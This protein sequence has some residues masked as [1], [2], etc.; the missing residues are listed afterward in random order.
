[1]AKGARKSSD[2]RP[3]HPDVAA[4][5]QFVPPPAKPTS[6][7]SDWTQAE[8]VLG[9]R[10]PLDVKQ[11]LAAYGSG[12]L[13]DFIRV[14]NPFDTIQ[15]YL[16]AINAHLEAD[17]EAQETPGYEGPIWPEPGGRLPWGST[18]NGDVLW[19]QTNGDPDDWTVIAWATRSEEHQHFNMPA[20]AFIRRWV[21]G[22]VKVKVSTD[23]FIKQAGFVF[24]PNPPLKG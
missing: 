22:K 20:I 16:D 6:P 17:R 18:T 3:A 12:V 24:V 23:H 19:W 14:W 5:L 1:M 4:L 10:V 9:F 21:T 8:R 2:D 11:Y 7:P 13:C 15:G